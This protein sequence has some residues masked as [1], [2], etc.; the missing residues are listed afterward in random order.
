MLP[1]RDVAP[2]TGAE[3]VFPF[4]RLVMLGKSYRSCSRSMGR[5]NPVNRDGFRC[6]AAMGI[7]AAF[8]AVGCRPLFRQLAVIVFIHQCPDFALR[9]RRAPSVREAVA[10]RAAGCA[11]ATLHLHRA[12]NRRRSATL[13]PAFQPFPPR[14]PIPR[15]K[16]A[17]GNRRA[18]A[19]A[20]PR[21]HRRRRHPA[22]PNV[23]GRTRPALQ[24]GEPR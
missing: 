11:R 1:G 13:L 21:P 7:G 16:P 20:G 5:L 3:D 6:V 23:A 18:C 10:G 19:S 15:P 12:R 24:P 2:L 9:W 8:G 22:P 14:G 17:R 4:T